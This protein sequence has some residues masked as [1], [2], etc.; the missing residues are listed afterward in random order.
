M[1]KSCDDNL[2]I[3]S[4]E[5]CS[6]EA[7]KE[8]EKIKTSSLFDKNDYQIFNN[9][10]IK[11][12]SD[13]NY[14]FRDP[15]NDN[16]FI[17]NENEPNKKNLCVKV[18]NNEYQINCSI[19]TN[20]KFFNYNKKNNK[21]EPINNLELPSQ[22]EYIF[23][24][25]NVYITPNLKKNDL[26]GNYIYDFK[27]EKAYCENKWYDWIII[28]NYHFNNNYYKDPGVYSKEDV[29]KCYKP[30]EIGKM[31][32]LNQN[33]EMKCINKNEAN[34]GLIKDKLDYSPIALIN[35]L[36]NN[37]D[38]LDGL[39]RLFLLD[40]INSLTN[41]E[42]INNNNNDRLIS[43]VNRI[44]NTSN[45]DILIKEALID[46]INTIKNNIVNDTNINIE[47]I[48]TN[49]RY[50][51]YKNPNFNENDTNLLTIRGM[52]DNNMLNYIILIH[53]YFLAY[54]YHDFIT[55]KVF[56]NI[57]YNELQVDS[58]NFV[59]NFK[60][61]LLKII[62]TNNLINL[63]ENIFKREE[64]ST[65]DKTRNLESY[66]WIIRTTYYRDNIHNK[67]AIRLINILYKSINLCYD[68]NTAFSKNILIYTKD[69]II[70]YKSIY[71][72]IET[73][74]S[75]TEYRLD[76]NNKN[77]DI[78]NKYLNEFNNFIYNLN[79]NRFEDL[80]LEIPFFKD[81][82][83]YLK[84]IQ[85]NYYNDNIE[86]KTIIINELNLKKDIIFY[87]IEDS[88]IT[89]KCVPFEYYDNEV[90]SYNK[91]VPCENKCNAE[92]CNT[93]PLCAI[94]CPKSCEKIEE[95]KQGNSCGIYKNSQD[96]ENINNTENNDE[97]TP[98][99][100]E[101]IMP[102]YFAI[103]RFSIKFLFIALLFYILYICYQIF[104]ET[105]LSVLNIFIYWLYYIYYLI[106]NFSFNRGR[107]SFYEYIRDNSISNYAKVVSK[108]NRLSK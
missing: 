104:G 99:D 8:L 10:F 76:K 89:N 93:D 103:F 84:Y 80:K 17:Y 7:L 13:L 75:N 79:I 6:F 21:C 62:D 59:Y 74:Y 9:D 14:K 36:G 69:A 108:V 58:Y 92:T 31:P 102:D 49:V 81:I 48:S 57:P 86:E 105:I 33:N 71:T 61:N 23:D 44:N 52:S 30:C 77:T 95:S 24:K 15:K 85:D 1:D 68:N 72:K 46:I 70:K 11:N 107:L 73:N 53:T 3:Q 63:N 67:Y 82:G 54:K 28:P 38:T 87:S 39:Y 20:N 96:N 37:Y 83:D 106:T 60:T 98:I 51:T 56:S 100:D 90:Q 2:F 18:N 5:K 32:Y 42:F 43:L 91:C 22:L 4:I 35:L 41:N 40:K 101:Y 94:Y 97:K 55:K 34:D 50:I 19:Q 16:N 12:N 29:R 47:N 65:A 78:R 88:E 64:I 25:N 26:E 45:N 66:N 27:P